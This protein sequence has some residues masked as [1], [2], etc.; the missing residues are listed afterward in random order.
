MKPVNQEISDPGKGDCFSA[1]LASLL[2]VPLSE[3]PKFRRDFGAD[4]MK[5]AKKWLAENYG[6]S[7]VTIQMQDWDSEEFCGGDLRL[8]GAVPGTP[9]IAGGKSPNF[10][11]CSHA[12]VGQT[13]I[14]ELNFVMTHDPS[15]SKKG[16]EG[17]P[18]HLYFF[19]P[20]HPEKLCR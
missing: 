11:N 20:L 16:I 8:V 17:N 7:I 4:M 14:H 6:L 9:C 5:E 13:D 12:V 2:E 1:C 3:V 19:V 10:P 18:T 15:P